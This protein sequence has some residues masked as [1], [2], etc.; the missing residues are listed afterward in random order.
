M[1]VDSK[2]TVDS[3]IDSPTLILNA[4]TSQDNSP[5]DPNIADIALDSCQQ[6]TN[7]EAVRSAVDPMDIDIELGHNETFHSVE[8]SCIMD[9]SDNNNEREDFKVP[10]QKIATFKTRQS[11][12][13]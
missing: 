12:L 7:G 2:E 13:W 1:E 4:P 3:L 11:Y 10:E 5:V 8:S 9:I 6:P